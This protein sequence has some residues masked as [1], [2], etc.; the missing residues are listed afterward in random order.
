[1]TVLGDFSGRIPGSATWRVLVASMG[2]PRPSAARSDVPLGK[3]DPIVQLG[4]AIAGHGPM[5]PR[6]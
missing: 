2:S 1:M 6:S 3:E 5:P 4:N